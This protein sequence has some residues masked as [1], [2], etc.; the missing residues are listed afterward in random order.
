MIYSPE[1][2]PIGKTFFYDDF[3]SHNVSK[4]V[5]TEEITNGLLYGCQNDWIQLA[6]NPTPSI[7]DYV[8]IQIGMV[9]SF[10]RDMMY[11]SNFPIFIIG[12]KLLNDKYVKVSWF[13]DN[14]LK[15][16]L[17]LSNSDGYVVDFYSGV[18]DNFESD[19]SLKFRIYENQ[20]FVYINEEFLAKTLVPNYIEWD[21]FLTA[22]SNGNDYSKISDFYIIGNGL[23]DNCAGEFRGTRIDLETQ[24]R[25]LKNENIASDANIDYSK[26][27][28]TGKVSN[29][30]LLNGEL[31]TK[32]DTTVL[33]NKKILNYVSFQ[34]INI[35]QNNNF[36]DF[37]I[38]LENEVPVNSNNQDEGYIIDAP[39][40]K[41]FVKENFTNQSIDDGYGNEVYGRLIRDNSL[42]IISFYSLKDNIESSYTFTDSKVIDLMI[43]K[44]MN[45][46]SLPENFILVNGDN[47][48]SGGGSIALQTHLSSLAAHD[49]QSVIV[50]FSPINYS[51]DTQKVE[52]HLKKIDEKLGYNGGNGILGVPSDGLFSDGLLDFTQDTKVK[53]A[54]DDFNEVLAELAPLPPSTLTNTDLQIYNSS[55]MKF[56]GLLSDGNINYETVPGVNADYIITDANF[57]LQTDS[58]S[59]NWADLGQLKL[60]INGMQV[61]NFDLSDNFDESLR[62]ETQDYTPLTS[63]NGF[64]KIISISKYNNFKKWQKGIAQIIIGS[65]DLRQGYNVIKLIHELAGGSQ[66]TKEW[67]A[68]YDND[69]GAIP[70]VSIPLLQPEEPISNKYLSGIRFYSINDQFSLSVVGNNLFNNVYVQNPLVVTMTGIPPYNISITD[71]NV[72]PSLSNPPEIGNIM[73]VVGK[74]LTITQGNVISNNLRVTVTPQ[75]PYGSHLAQQSVSNN[76]LLNTYGYNSTDL[77]E[78]FVDERYRLSDNDG[79][80][81][82]NNYTSI[83][84]IRTG[85]WNSA[86]GLTN[87]SSEAQVFNGKLIYP[88]INFSASYLPQQS[89]NYSTFTGEKHYL[90]TFYRTN[91][92]SYGVLT[93]TGLNL[94]NIQA[95]GKAKVEIKLPGLTGWLDLGKSF[96][97]GSFNGVN[98]DGCRT[99]TNGSDFSWSSGSFSTASSG[100]MIIIRI[101]IFDVPTPVEC[102]YIELK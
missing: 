91:P 80:A 66:E 63:N 23:W 69:S 67:K 48:E 4:W 55:T 11:G 74:I 40:N 86:I 17:R 102:T 68:F 13:Q 25:N 36:V 42:W 71:S 41:V 30:D 85:R 57:I 99:I 75:S 92:I 43:I 101:S 2:C 27:N 22:Q 62:N 70:I 72:S 8:E 79:N 64:I 54:I 60:Q 14:D 28:L 34:N 84:T 20:I 59:F 78:R 32:D 33:A 94:S 96:D 76:I 12:D 44:R 87:S 21:Y 88:K 7:N 50:G 47:G 31:H 53:D 65:N 3:T 29:I 38:I 26:L 89:V 35:L 97:A 39:Y 95:G 37:T 19:A 61:D 16:N 100:Y 51:P 45:F 52:E 49:A 81:Y 98:G 5:G 90:R 93:L 18:P 46:L 1:S 15:Y 24:A 9:F 82:P 10:R 6:A 73:N 56:S 77:V 58:N 83:P